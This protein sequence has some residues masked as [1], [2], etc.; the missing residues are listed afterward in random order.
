[1][2]VE[3]ANLINGVE[4]EYE[5]LVKNIANQTLNNINI[6]DVIPKGLEYKNSY[7]VQLINNE[8]TGES[9]LERVEN[10]DYDEKT[11]TVKWNIETLEPDEEITVIAVAKVNSDETEQQYNNTAVAIME[12]GQR[13]ESNI[14]INN[15]VVPKISIEK[16]S[17]VENMYIKET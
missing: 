12:D 11:K 9:S 13:I 1:M 10:K 4:I 5:I 17:S 14:T 3:D 15:K 7:Y 6:E 2:Y 8:E 16:A